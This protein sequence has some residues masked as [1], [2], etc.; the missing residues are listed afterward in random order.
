MNST[1]RSLVAC[2]TLTLLATGCDH[3]KSG[4]AQVS[5]ASAPG[6][7][8]ASVT[9]QWLGKWNGPE[10]T[11]LQLVGGHG[12]YDVT[13]QNLDGPRTF[14]GNA[15]G[16]Q[17]EFVRDGVKES[18]RATNGAETG[19]KWLIEKSDCLTVRAGEGYCAD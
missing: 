12:K 1:F 13:V 6:A 5:A 10:G 3:R 18:L 14:Q 17:I 7:T 16:E 11:F 4:S 15:A 19:M 8:P 2:A 9:D